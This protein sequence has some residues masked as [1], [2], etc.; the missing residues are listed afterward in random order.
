MN[1]IVIKNDFITL[2][3]TDN[4]I[5]VSLL[6][7]EE[8]FDVGKL[9]IKVLKDTKLEILY[10]GTDEKLDIEYLIDDN[11]NFSVVEI[12]K[13][14]QIKI[15]YKYYIGLNS[16]VD[17]TKFYDC[18]KVKEL[19]IICFNGDASSI[20]YNL[21]TIAKDEQKYNL[22]IYH[23]SKNTNS[24]ICNHGVSMDGGKIDFNITGIVYKGITGCIMNQNSRIIT[25]NDNKC[26]IK[27]N[28]LIDEN[29]VIANHS[30]LIGKFDDE[31]LFY[32]ESRGIPRENS[33]NLL[34]KGFLKSGIEEHKEIDKILDE[35][36]G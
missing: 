3:Q 18:T 23:N 4:N 7:K 25:L 30:G 31:E 16:N 21:K 29:D 28:L 35:Y 5:E 24:N 19:D 6:E 20:N 1:K 32:L 2:K 10:E 26:T 33:I 8:V 11:V 15:Q 12:R 34:T 22:M 36:W 13:E 17:I 27:P 14:K 9:N